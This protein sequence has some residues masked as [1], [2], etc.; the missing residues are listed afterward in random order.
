MAEG[1][2]EI[3]AQATQNENIGLID[4]EEELSRYLNTE[5]EKSEE[6]GDDDEDLIQKMGSSEDDD[7]PEN[8]KE[9]KK[10]PEG[11]EIGGEKKE[12]KS[13]D[14]KEEEK[15][16]GNIVHY[17]NDRFDLKLNLK[18]LPEELDRQQEAEIVEQL[19]TR[20]L[21][22]A[23]SKLA[24]Y[25]QINDILKDEE[26]KDFIKAKSEGKTFADFVKDYSGETAGKSD[27]ELVKDSLKQKYP[28]MSEEDINNAIEGYKDR[29]VLEKLAKAERDANI[30]NERKKREEAETKK[31]KDAEEA[32]RKRDED[33]A[34]FT[35]YVQ[36]IN[37]VHGVPVSKE[38]KN[39]IVQ[40]A[41]QV[42]KDGYTYIDRA[43]QSDEG[44][45]LATLGILHLE[46][47]IKANATLS[48]NKNA[49]SLVDKLLSDAKELQS[50]SSV[51][52]EEGFN[53]EIANSF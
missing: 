22:G 17:L 44:T 15:E 9:K 12:E 52:E 38:M 3:E 50:G 20:V 35:N 32:Q 19:Y 24:E 1:Q 49:N 43:L 45:V 11:I 26:V 10:D 33:V 30:E 23:N 48:G 31:V 47:L 46:R 21:E 16:Y 40:A 2:H 53:P 13:E 4:N 6:T 25:S 36:R 18:E 51:K 37:K 39:Q 8:E 42:D 41:T 34:T 5:P 29:G 27:E 14:K 28:S 7:D